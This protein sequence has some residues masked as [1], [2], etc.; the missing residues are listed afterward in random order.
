MPH[1]A[2]WTRRTACSSATRSLP[3]A[4]IRPTSA[5]SIVVAR[6]AAGEAA[7]GRGSPYISAYSPGLA[8]P[9]P[10]WRS[11][12]A[13][14]SSTG[15]AL[16]TPLPARYAWNPCSATASSNPVLSPNSR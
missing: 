9:K 10:T 7:P 12:P 13:R 15:S 2:A 5:R 3:T 14:R 1:A 8:R 6:A 4:A 11:Q 16:G